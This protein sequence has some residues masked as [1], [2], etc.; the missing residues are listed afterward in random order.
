MRAIFLAAVLG[1]V[2]VA[3]PAAMPKQF[4]SVSPVAPV[5]LSP[6]KTESAVVALQIFDGFHI[7]SNP[8]AN[9][10][11]IATRLDVKGAK[12]LTP[13]TPVYPK[14]KPY[15]L[16]GSPA[17]ISVYDGKVEITVPVTAEAGAKRIKQN[18]EGTLKFQA[19]NDKICFFPANVPISIP[20]TVQ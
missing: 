14:G 19:C 5:K 12:G 7:Q 2:A 13:G 3:G 11:L 8:A 9:P 16:Q 10:Q 20:V 6:G 17:E 1:A 18:L 15:R 4:L